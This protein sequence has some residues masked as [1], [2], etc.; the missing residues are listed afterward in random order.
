MISEPDD[1]IIDLDV[2]DATCGATGGEISSIVGGGVGAYTYAWS[3]GSSMSS[4][5][6]LAPD[7]YTITVTDANYCSKSSTVSVG[8]IG[9][10]IASITV[11][12]P[13]SCAGVPDA[14]I[15]GGAVSAA[16]PLLYNWS[17]G[18]TSETI[19]NLSAGTYYLTITDDW[20]CTGSVSETLSLPNGINLDYFVTNLKCFGSNDGA[21]DLVI[22]GGD[23]PFSFQWSNS[24]TETSLS[25]LEPGQYSV[26]ITDSRD[27]VFT[28]DF[29]VNQP[30][31][32]LFEYSKKDISCYG[33]KNGSITMYASGG[34][35][36]YSY[37]VSSTQ[38]IANAQSVN[39]LDA[40]NY[41]ISV[42]DNNNCMATHNV[43]ISQPAVLSAKITASNP[44]C[45]G[46]NDGFIAVYPIGGTAP[47]SYS[48]NNMEMDTSVY[49]QL[50]EGNYTVVLTD[51]NGCEYK[52]E[53]VRINE[54]IYECLDIPTAFTPNGDGINDNWEIRNLDFYP[55]AYVYV[56][57]RWGQKIYTGRPT[58]EPWDGTYN[59]RLL[60]VG[61]YLY[62]INP[63][64]DAGEY[65]GTVSIVY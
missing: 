37:N 21:I 18:S 51:A 43:S 27:C 64:N 17:N 16:M 57:N 41:S 40:G 19:S 2:I 54:A 28:Q 45:I 22:S 42:K 48:F 14:V 53:N 30:E 35:E 5:F 13:I 38:V 39:S 55:G 8:R 46:H 63:H 62:I 11:E 7:D 47:Y 60:P 12:H 24:S 3:N 31:P 52:L 61:A 65:K 56:F 59:G 32:I 26:T 44:S 6:G 23:S 15:S 34:S 58:T 20:G 25:S 49:S 1:I 10:V 33:E 29:V 50:R 9:N 4:L 36:P